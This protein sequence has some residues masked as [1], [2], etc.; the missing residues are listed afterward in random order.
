MTIAPK[1]QRE[2]RKGYTWRSCPYSTRDLSNRV[3]SGERTPHLVTSGY[4]SMDIHDG[5]GAIGFTCLDPTCPYYLGTATTVLDMKVRNQTLNR[6]TGEYII[7]T[8]N[9]PIPVCTGTY[10]WET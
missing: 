5:H 8:I 10:F 3:P 4:M 6:Q 2:I 1:I 7:E 9:I